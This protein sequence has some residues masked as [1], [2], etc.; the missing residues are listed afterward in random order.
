LRP[1]VR[2]APVE[3]AL[4]HRELGHPSDHRRAVEASVGPLCRP[5]LG[6]VLVEQLECADRLLLPLQLQVTHVPERHA[7]RSPDR[8][9]AH[10]DL[11]GISALLQSCG[12]VHGVPGDEPFSRT[13]DRASHDHPRVDADTYRQSDRV[14]VLQR[15]V[16]AVEAT[17]HPQGS[18]E[19]P[20][21]VVL[22]RGRYAEDRDDRV[23]DEL[24]DDPAFGL[25]LVPHGAE[26]R[27]QN[28]LQALRV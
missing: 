24:L 26:E 17:S 22:V 15:T 16:Q 25:D 2:G 21:R 27:R 8:S 9:L 11:T 10:Q 7:A 14:H 20:R 3:H 12:D 18:P 6:H 28:L 23:A 1:P 13:G 4:H 19:R 5:R